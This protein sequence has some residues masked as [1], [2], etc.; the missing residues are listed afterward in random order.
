METKLDRSITPTVRDIAIKLRLTGWIS[1]WIQ[2]GLG[3]VAVLCLLFAKSGRSFSTKTDP[4]IGA[5]MFWAGIGVLVLCFSIY[6]AFRYTRIAKGLLNPNPE[7]HPKKA[8]TTRL[9]R[10]AIITSLVG[11]LLALFGAGSTAGVLVAK[12]VSQPPGV[13]ITDPNKIIRALDVFVEVA[14]IDII[15]AH[16]VGT[17]TSLWLVDQIHHH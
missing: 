6:L 10:I 5:G 8:D 4:G 15:A 16:L 2:L 3:V 17:V 14:N 7:L 12:S 9:V 13:A 11:M 1:F